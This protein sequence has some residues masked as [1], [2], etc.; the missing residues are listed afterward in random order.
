MNQK[1]IGNYIVTKRKEK[2]MTRNDL[3]AAIGVSERTIRQWESGKYVP[4]Y[5]VIDDLCE[6]LDI[7]I[8]ELITGED[9]GDKSIHLY[10]E[11]EILD[12]L[13]TVQATERQNNLFFTMTIASMML[14]FA[15]V[16]SHT[17]IGNILLIM[18]FLVATIAIVIALKK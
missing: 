3:A 1:K 7:S 13:H 15:K 18:T 16:F 11:E 14:L 6:E 5:F 9:R 17:I 8:G 2:E 10:D 4:D 12:L